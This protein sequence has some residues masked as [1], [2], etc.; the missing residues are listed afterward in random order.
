MKKVKD[1]FD[2]ATLSVPAEL[3]QQIKWFGKEGKHSEHLGYILTEMQFLQREYP[4]S[5]W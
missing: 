5:I 4:N 2:E 3:K 1:V